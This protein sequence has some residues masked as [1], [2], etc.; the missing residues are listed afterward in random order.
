MN[1]FTFLL[2]QVLYKTRVEF[3]IRPQVL[4]KTQNDPSTSL[5]LRWGPARN[6]NL[7]ILWKDSG[8]KSYFE[9]LLETGD[10]SPQVLYKTRVQT[11]GRATSLIQNAKSTK[12]ASLIHGWGAR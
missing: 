10:L 3:P 12:L 1:I 4:Y 6:A 2:P 11:P 5:I 7:T 9:V 8:H